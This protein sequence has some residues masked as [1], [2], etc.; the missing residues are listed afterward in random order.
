MTL[1]KSVIY[2]CHAGSQLSGIQKVLKR[3]DSG[4][5]IT[6]MTN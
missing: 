2:F 6:G 4:L 1:I 3:L 5:K